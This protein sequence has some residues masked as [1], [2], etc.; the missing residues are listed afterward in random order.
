MTMGKLIEP[1]TTGNSDVSEY[2]ICDVTCGE[3]SE[4]T[5]GSW[6]GIAIIQAED[7]VDPGSRCDRSLPFDCPITIP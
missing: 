5:E 2:P 1:G 3:P 4:F 7:A 6:L